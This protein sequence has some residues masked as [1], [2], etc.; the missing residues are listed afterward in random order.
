MSSGLRYTIKK[1]ILSKIT[2]SRELASGELARGIE[3]VSIESTS[4][5]DRITIKYSVSQ[6]NILGSTSLGGAKV[7]W[8]TVWQRY[9]SCDYFHEMK[10]FI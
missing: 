9:L 7:K 8:D 4:L 1:I 5:L 2:A 3:D 6:F 10:N